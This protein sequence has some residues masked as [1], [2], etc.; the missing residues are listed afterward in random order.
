M[1]LSKLRSRGLSMKI[2]SAAVNAFD[3]AKSETKAGI[4]AALCGAFG[5]FGGFV[6]YV[7][8]T[9]LFEHGGVTAKIVGVFFGLLASIAIA[10]FGHGLWETIDEG[11]VTL[12]RQSRRTLLAVVSLVVVFE[13]SAS[14]VEDFVRAFA[15]D[16]DGLRRVAADIAG[17]DTQAARDL[18]DDSAKRMFELLTERLAKLPRNCPGCVTTPEARLIALLPKERLYRVFAKELQVSDDEIFATYIDP[19][20]HMVRSAFAGACVPP[21]RAAPSASSMVWQRFDALNQPARSQASIDACRAE[22]E[23]ADD[24]KRHAA[25]KGALQSLMARHDLYD[26]ASFKL[27]ATGEPLQLGR[28]LE[29]RLA[30]QRAQCEAIRAAVGQGFREFLCA[31]ITNLPVA[32]AASGALVPIGEM[33]AMNR[34]L[35]AA[36]F[37]GIVPP[38]PVY[39]WDLALLY[40]IWSTA[41]VVVGVYLSIAVFAAPAREA[42]AVK[43]VGGQVLIAVLAVVF[44]AV[45]A[46]A[47]LAV[48]RVVPFLWTLMFDPAN[49]NIEAFHPFFTLIP[50]LV[51][52]LAAGSLIGFA[53]P[54]WVTLPAFVI[55]ALVVWANGIDKADSGGSTIAGFALL[56]LLIT[57]ITPVAGG[58]FGV[59]MIVAGAWIVPALGLALMLPFLKPGASLPQWWGFVALAGGVAVALW[60]ATM[61]SGDEVYRGAVAAGGLLAALTGVLILR[62]VP[63]RELWPLLALTIGLALVGG[64]AAFQQVTFGGALEALHPVSQGPARVGTEFDALRYLYSLRSEHEQPQGMQEVAPAFLAPPTNEAVKEALRLELALTGSVGFWLTLGLLVAWSLKQ[65]PRASEDDAKRPEQK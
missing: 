54:G 18:D 45:L 2:F 38:L 35:L 32:K 48:S 13:L 17:R 15:G 65:G 44:A 58:L 5:V 11:R 20:R 40:V 12:T 31:D 41:A 25:L 16:F 29:A 24:G 1:E 19:A 52:S 6:L 55:V 22:L 28:A 47:M 60:V 50:W 49:A 14:A 3:A 59:V 4:I 46:A 10:S 21:L 33:R 51:Q 30:E 56:G 53:I 23:G 62:R 26:A 43:R 64:S 42:P 27:D 39:W 37:P 9:H 61:L 34:E 7:V 63:V 36:A 8:F 57:S